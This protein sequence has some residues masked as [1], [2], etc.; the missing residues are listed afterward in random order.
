MTGRG[1]VCPICGG[2]FHPVCPAGLRPLEHELYRRA[3]GAL[4]QLGAWVLGYVVL[5]R[6]EAWGA[7]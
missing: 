1:P 5:V 7:G 2:P 6:L 3:A 4:V